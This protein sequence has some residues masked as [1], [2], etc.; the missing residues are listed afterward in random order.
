MFRFVA[1]LSILVIAVSQPTTLAAQTAG[2][3][4]AERQVVSETKPFSEWT[5]A[6]KEDYLL[7]APIVDRIAID[8]GITGTDR[9]TM[10]DGTA[11][12]DAQSQTVN[13]RVTF[14]RFEDGR[15]EQGF[16]DCYC[17]NIAAYRLDR[18][19][20]LNMVPVSVPRRDLGQ[21]AAITWWVDDYLMM[22]ADRL[23]DGTSVPRPLEWARDVGAAMV[24]RQLVYDTDPNLTNW[25]YSGDYRM[26]IID[27]GRA[28]RTH[29]ELRSFEDLPLPNSIPRR[30]YDAM[31][32]LT[33]ELLDETFEDLDLI[34]G[35]QKDAILARRDLIIE[36]FDALIADPN[37]SESMV[38]RGD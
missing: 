19:I 10:D 28:F 22:E 6:E 8:V 18:L 13:E 20:G 1:A 12:H 5:D 2:V 29:K 31:K 17:Y 14:M 34:T 27:F 7:N 3:T 23:E 21:D 38:L 37:R 9:V 33:R 25:M 4:D 15:T 24:F 11:Q 35:T 16:T 32:S 26:W 30:V 36:H